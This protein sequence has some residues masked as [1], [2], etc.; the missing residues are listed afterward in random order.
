MNLLGNFLNLF[1]FFAPQAQ[2]GT[3]QCSQPAQAAKQLR[4]GQSAT[5]Q[6][7]RQ[8]WLEPACR[9]FMQ[10][11]VFP[12]R[13]KKSNL[14]G[15]QKYQAFTKQLSRCDVVGT[16]YPTPNAQARGGIG[17]LWYILV[18]YA[19]PCALN[20]IARATSSLWLCFWLFVL[21]PIMSIACPPN[22]SKPIFC[23]TGKK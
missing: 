20:Q 8:S 21:Q 22:E 2:H 5:M 3:A 14:P 19:T 10:L 18:V 12:K 7:S 9:E 1:A 6:A 4:T 13:I 23:P 16:T 15:L 17:T 11:D